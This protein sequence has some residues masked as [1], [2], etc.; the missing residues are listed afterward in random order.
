MENTNN[1]MRNALIVLV[2]LGEVRGT[3]R[4][5]AKMNS[6]DLT[7]AAVTIEKQVGLED[8][9]RWLQRTLA[10]SDEAPLK[11]MQDMQMSM[12]LLPVIWFFPDGE[13]A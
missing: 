11:V 6:L 8:L 1:T 2:E 10:N 9:P 12:K 5:K 4:I 13:E 7:K 3:F